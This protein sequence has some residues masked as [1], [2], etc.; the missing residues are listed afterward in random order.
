M[1][2][3]CKNPNANN[4]ERYGGKG[5][6]VCD[7]WKERIVGFW[8]FVEDMGEKPSESHSLDRIDNLGDYSSENCKWSTLH[9]QMSNC[10][11]NLKVV[12]VRKEHN[13]YIAKLTVNNITYISRFK[14]LEEAISHRKFLE[15]KYL[16]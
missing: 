16:K 14:T 4:Y 6:K 1:L 9:E 10:S 5:I 3:R 15:K 2:N 7:R 13:K 11:N 12:G 8:N